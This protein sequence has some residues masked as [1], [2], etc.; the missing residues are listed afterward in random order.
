MSSSDSSCD[1][2]VIPTIL[3]KSC[4]DV[5]IK[6]ITIIVNLSF[7]E[8]S[9]PTTFKHAPVN[10][11]L[12]TQLTSRWI[13]QLSSNLKSEFYFKGFGTYHSCSYIITFGIIPINH[14]LPVCI[15][16]VSF[17]WNCFF[18]IQNDLL[19]AI[20]KQQVSASVLLDL[21]AAFDTIDYKIFLF[22][23]SS[24]YGL[25]NTALNLIASYLLDRTQS[26]SIQSHSTPPSN[27]FIGIPQVSVLGPYFFSLYT[28]PICQLFTKASISYHLYADDTQI[29]ISFSPNQSH[30]SL[31][32]LSS[33]THDE[34]Y[35]WLTSNRLSVNSSKTEFLIIGNSRQGNKIQSSS[36][37]FCVD[38]ISPSTYPQYLHETLV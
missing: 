33:S 19:L 2:D 32:L 29:Y 25:S 18:R 6:P 15:S 31:S 5:L 34:V 16:A 13:P 4:L 3:L 24:F 27:I 22:R 12:K 17:H 14:S 8:G 1:L 21:S 30:D 10:P 11:L 36:I 38:I 35:A 37:V 28:S 9:F 26:V 20:N 7:S 23:L